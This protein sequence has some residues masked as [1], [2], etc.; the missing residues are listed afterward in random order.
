MS[1]ETGRAS[2]RG[3]IRTG[4]GAAGFMLAAAGAWA[5]GVRVEVEGGHALA[6]AWCRNCHAVEP[7]EIVGPYA[8]IPSFVE[9]ARLPSTTASSLHA[10]LTT[11]HGDMPD[12]KLKSSEIDDIVNYIL[13]LKGS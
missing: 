2:R 1:R 3:K 10:F 9:I 8:D 11:P 12:I 13:S 5:A 7:K 6:T 4:L